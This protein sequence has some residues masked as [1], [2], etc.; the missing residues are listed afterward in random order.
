MHFFRLPLSL[1][2][3]CVAHSMRNS[4]KSVK[5]FFFCFGCE[6][7]ATFLSR[8][9]EYFGGQN[10]QCACNPEQ[11]GSELSEICPRSR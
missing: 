10:R 2:S 11:S 7:S 6:A 5:K 8:S 1:S 9:Y 4:V 3:H